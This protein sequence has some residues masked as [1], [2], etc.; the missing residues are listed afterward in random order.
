MRDEEE[1]WGDGALEHWGI[2]NTPS[3][4]CSISPMP[5]RPLHPF[6]FIL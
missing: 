4:K 5:Q 1:E 3:L 6:A 2:T